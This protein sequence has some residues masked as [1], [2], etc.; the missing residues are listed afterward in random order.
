MSGKK[1]LVKYPSG[2]FVLLISPKD[3]LYIST[4]IYFDKKGLWQEDSLRTDWRHQHFLGDSEAHAYEQAEKWM[5]EK[6][7]DPLAIEVV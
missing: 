7:G 5:K 6:L 1:Y 3:S 4:F 2:L